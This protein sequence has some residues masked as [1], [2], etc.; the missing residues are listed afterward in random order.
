MCVWL[1]GARSVRQQAQLLQDVGSPK[2]N[3]TPAR[4]RG[5]ALQVR[6]STPIRPAYHQR[7]GA[8]LSHLRPAASTRAHTH[9]SML[10]AR[11]GGLTCCPHGRRPQA[12][13]RAGCGASM[14]GSHPGG[15]HWSG[16]ALGSWG[17]SSQCFR[18]AARFPVHPRLL[19]MH[20]Q[21]PQAEGKH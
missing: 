14:P 19:A 4:A 6:F 5:L 20:A 16:S 12:R 3:V 8:S 10:N 2:L 21:T 1:V 9:R 7:N 13:P 17:Q 15:W 11:E 18:E